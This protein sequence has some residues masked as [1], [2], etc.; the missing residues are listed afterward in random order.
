VVEFNKKPQGLLLKLDKGGHVEIEI[1]WFEENNP[2]GGPTDSEGF[3]RAL[4]ANSAKGNF[5][6]PPKQHIFRKDLKHET[7]VSLLSKKNGDIFNF[8]RFC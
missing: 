6:P 3:F 1:S 2:S 7:A 8:F 5:I 4:P